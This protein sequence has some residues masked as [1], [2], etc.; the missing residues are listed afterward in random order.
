MGSSICHEY[1]PRKDFKKREKKNEEVLKKVNLPLAKTIQ[2]VEINALTTACQLSGQTVFILTAG[3]SLGL[4]MILLNRF[5][6]II[7]IAHLKFYL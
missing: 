6:Y 4:P 1:S 7:L 5:H 3:M 2:H